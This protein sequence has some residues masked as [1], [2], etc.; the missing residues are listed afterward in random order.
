MKDSDNGDKTPK[1]QPKTPDSIAPS[2]SV[3]AC[4]RGRKPKESKVQSRLEM[5]DRRVNK[6]RS[7]DG[8]KPESSINPPSSEEDDTPHYFTNGP[9]DVL[10]PLAEAI[11]AATHEADRD[12][13]FQIVRL[14][15]VDGIMWAVC[16]DCAVSRF[17]RAFEGSKV[18]ARVGCAH[19]RCQNALQSEEI[20]QRWLVLG[21]PPINLS[22]PPRGT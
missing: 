6:G 22:D 8:Q 13:Q 7:S 2:R 11:L 19:C 10:L 4:P 9:G 18:V 5:Y 16:D 1:T 12:Q 17:P 14:Y 20:M 3:F 15:H 21:R